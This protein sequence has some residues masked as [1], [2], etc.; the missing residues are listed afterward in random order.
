MKPEE[1]LALLKKYGTSDSVIEHVKAVRDYA[2]ELAAQHDCDRELVEAG[3]LLHDIGRSRTHSIDHA[4][5]G[6]A[7]LR[8]EGVDERIIRITERHIGAGLTDEDAVNLGLPPG[9]YLPK[10]MEEKIVCQ[11]DNLMGSKDRISIHEA[12]A[13]AEE[14]WSPDGVKRLIQL[15]FEVF[16]PVEVSINSRACDKKQI[17]EAIGSLDVL[18]KK[19]VEIGT[20]KILLYGSDAEK[21]A[22]NLKK[23][24]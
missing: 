10:T 5:I 3:A 16:K 17:E 1:A 15:Q 2:M 19:K 21:A 20:C 23:M 8:Q 18:Y 13:T 4:I 6:A 9:D 22:G 14:K 24:A 11:A 7:I 12:I